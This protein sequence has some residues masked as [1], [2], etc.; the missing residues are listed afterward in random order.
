MLGPVLRAHTLL[1]VAFAL[2]ASIACSA[3]GPQHVELPP[4]AATQ[5]A[6][7]SEPPAPHFEKRPA[8]SRGESCLMW[9]VCGCNVGCSKIAVARSDLKDGLRADVVSGT[10][11]GTTAY[12]F[13]EKDSLGEPVF[14]LSPNKPGGIYVCELP[15][16]KYVGYLCATSISGEID[17][18]KCD[19][20]CN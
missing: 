13:R 18:H 6:Q 9:Y 10:G 1:G 14:G 17:A 5:T 8:A 7:Q 15:S 3:D 16:A 2:M 12:V 20:G 19:M 4:P 11:A